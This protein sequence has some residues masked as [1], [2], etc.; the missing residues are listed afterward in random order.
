MEAKGGLELRGA[1]IIPDIHKQIMVVDLGIL[2]FEL[3]S[4]S[5]VACPSMSPQAA[6]EISKL[7]IIG[8]DHAAFNGGE[9]VAEV[10]TVRSRQPKG[11]G[12]ASLKRRSQRFA[13]IFQQQ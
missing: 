5:H 8:H 10:E 3:F 13:T 2:G 9:V 6:A 1:Q 11:P 12:V 7:I 4:V